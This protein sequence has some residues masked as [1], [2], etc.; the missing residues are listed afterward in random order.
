MPDHTCPQCKR[1]HDGKA[2]HGAVCS[3]TCGSN[4]YAALTGSPSLFVQDLA[5]KAWAERA[6]RPRAGDAEAP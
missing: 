6:R 2:G 4:L 1:R 5:R 3:F